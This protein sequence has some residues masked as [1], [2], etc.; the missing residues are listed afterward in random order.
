[1]EH[2]L[3]PYMAGRTERFV[4][5]LI[6]GIIQTILF[7]IILALTGSISD[8]FST[9]MESAFEVNFEAFGYSVF[10]FLILQGYL[11]I[12]QGQTIGKY[13]LGMKIVNSE[14]EVPTPTRVLGLRYLAVMIIGQIPVAGGIFTL[15]DAL[16]I[17]RSDK[18]CI[19]DLMADTYVV[20]VKQMA[21]MTQGGGDSGGSEESD[22]QPSIA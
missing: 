17:F 11:L 19:H 3:A 22:T 21:T 9:D 12:K 15:V 20:D 16:F 14:G 6:D 4:G 7:F 18:R 5:A 13:F 2:H 10:V 8:L 1:M